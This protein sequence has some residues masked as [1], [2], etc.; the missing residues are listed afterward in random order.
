[1]KY[2][3]FSFLA[4]CC[5]IAISSVSA[6]VFKNAD[7]QISK[8]ADHSWVI[9]TTDMGAMYLLE[10]ADKALLIDTGTKCDSLD[11]IVKKITNKPL[12]VVL[13][14]T[15]WDHAGNIRFFP[16]VYLHPA[17][18]VLLAKGYTG[19]LHFV[20]DGDIFDLGGRKV[21]VK[22]TP[23]HTPGS[24]V[25]LDKKTRSCFTGDAFGSGQVWL[26]L[27]PF[28]PMSLYIKSCNKMLGLM[29]K[30]IDSL[31]NGHYPYQKEAMDKN[32]VIAMRNLALTI[33]NGTVKNTEPFPRK[34]SI[35]CDNPMIA[36]EGKVAIV[37]DPE[38][39]K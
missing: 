23:A 10:G 17:D 8:I 9:E 15:H 7:L 4:T 2:S 22:H 37:Y 13:T 33:E 5:F 35:G 19:I 3:K 21:E 36:T 6:Q 14:H 29:D 12:Y 27:K 39:I 26:Q 32:Y 30:G 34:V 16:E 11:I 18:T 20:K 25:L 1:M 24:I 28:S 31:Y 38:H